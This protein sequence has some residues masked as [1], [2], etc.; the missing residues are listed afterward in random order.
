MKQWLI[1]KHTSIRS[2]K[3]YIGQT[4]KTM[5][6]R[7]GQHLSDSLHG[8]NSHFHKAIRLYG[9]D[10]WTHEVLAS[11]IDTQ[12]EANAL[13]IYFIKK[14][15][16]FENGY[17]LTEGGNAAITIIGPTRYAEIVH[18]VHKHYGHEYLTP[19]DL[20][21]KYNIHNTALTKVLRSDCNNKV[22]K[23]W[24]VFES[25]NSILLEEFK[26]YVST[27][28]HDVYGTE[29]CTP[30]ELSGKYGLL[31]SNVRKVVNGTRNQVGGWRMSEMYNAPTYSSK[32]VY[33]YDLHDN[34]V[35]VYSS[36]YEASIAL[37][38]NKKRVSGWLSTK[39]EYEYE[40]LTY[41]YKE[42]GVNHER[43]MEKKDFDRL[44]KLDEH[45]VK[46][47]M[48]PKKETNGK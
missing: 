20:S 46:A 19:L 30:S 27:F 29:V 18:W 47:M 25:E 41:T 13:E 9:K 6:R 45:A 12:E 37:G 32:K 44:A 11:N 4:C 39:D 16:T 34:L 35:T 15:D 43:D 1:Y 36:S 3:S 26:E 40:N 22:Y 21:R 33:V 17:N 31:T 42:S 28:Y 38:L 7:W 48:T 23:G 5:E 2:G 14:Y 8:S 10:N 24:Q